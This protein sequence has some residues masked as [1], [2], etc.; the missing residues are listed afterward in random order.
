MCVRQR[1]GEGEGEGGREQ[2]W[3]PGMYWCGLWTESF[4]VPS[5]R[6]RSGAA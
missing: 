2:A 1:E 4:T 5:D 3:S 6:K